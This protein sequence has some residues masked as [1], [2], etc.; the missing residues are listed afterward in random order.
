MEEY[1]GNSV[2]SIIE[3]VL[4]E[5]EEQREISRKRARFDGDKVETALVTH[6]T[7]IQNLSSTVQTYTVSRE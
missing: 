4:E 3:E 2:D 5:L 1:V 6:L 7:W